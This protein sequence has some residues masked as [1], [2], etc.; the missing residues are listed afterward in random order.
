MVMGAKSR[1]S[2]QR[3]IDVMGS[4]LSA[5]VVELKAALV[6]QKETATLRPKRTS[7]QIFADRVRIRPLLAH[8]GH[9]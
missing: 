4:H 6:K 7:R 1:L 3:S 9:W 2:A 5:M 8:R